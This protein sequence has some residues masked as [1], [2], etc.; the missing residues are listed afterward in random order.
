VRAW[1]SSRVPAA[2]RRICLRSRV[3]S[4]APTRRS[5]SA[6]P[7]DSVGWLRF[8]RAAA[9]IPP[10]RRSPGTGAD[11]A[12]QHRIFCDTAA[13]INFAGAVAYHARRKRRHKPCVQPPISISASMKTR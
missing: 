2:V 8:S 10:F 3:T 4:G 6:S 11:G 1:A 9:V 12:L 5:S 7:A 13:K